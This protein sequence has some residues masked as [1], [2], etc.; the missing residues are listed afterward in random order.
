MERALATAE[1]A[2]QRAATATQHKSRWRI[3]AATY[4]RAE[5]LVR[6]GRHEEGLAACDELVRHY[7]S[8]TDGPSQVLIAGALLYRGA[9]LRALGRLEEEIETCDEVVR[10]FAA[11]PDPLL[12]DQAAAASES[13]L[14]ALAA[15]GTR[16]GLGGGLLLRDARPDEAGDVAEL[17]LRAFAEYRSLVDASFLERFEQDARA[18]GDRLAEAQVVVAERSARLVGTVTLYA[19]S[20]RY[21]MPGW[22]ADWSL[23][24]LLAVDP[25]ARGTGA[26]RLLVGEC[27]RR[28]RELGTPGIG[29]HTAPFMAAA[30]AVYESLGFRRSPAH[31]APMPGAPPAL[32]YLLGFQSVP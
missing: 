18:V 29:L 26:G 16:P 28:A 17:T 11:S 15:L 5:A 25:A 31:D 14:Q 3:A 6:L 2:L 21:G 22:P 32:A 8:A 24:R 23:I 27:V 1:A 12:R 10:R 7:G 9:A 13:R 19:D 30:Q 4:S 20:T